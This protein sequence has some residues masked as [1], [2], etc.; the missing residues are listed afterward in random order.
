MPFRMSPQSLGGVSCV[1]VQ[2][3][4]VK[5]DSP[6]V[7]TDSRLLVDNIAV[8]YSPSVFVIIVR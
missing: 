7:T 6:F 4:G 5:A 1:A 2:A 3:K 8:A